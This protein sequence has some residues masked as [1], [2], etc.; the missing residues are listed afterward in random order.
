MQENTPHP[1]P[2]ALA[3]CSYQEFTPEMGAAVR[4]T[5]GAP[6]WKLPYPLIGHAR[7]ITPASSMLG[8]ERDRYRQVYEQRLADTGVY[9]ITAELRSLAQDR[10]EPLVLL[11]FDGLAKRENWC[12]RTMFSRWWHETTGQEVPELGAVPPPPPLM[13]F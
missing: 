9:R 12:H 11:C 8:M 7:L 10:Q 3:T 13:L 1:A 5:V 2:P 4:T 6:R